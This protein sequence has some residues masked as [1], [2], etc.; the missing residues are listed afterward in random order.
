M[1]DNPDD[2]DPKW[3]APTRI[4]HGATLNKPTV[5]DLLALEAAKARAEQSKPAPK[6]RPDEGRDPGPGLMPSPA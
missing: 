3:S 5:S 4:W 2:A 1:C 6:S